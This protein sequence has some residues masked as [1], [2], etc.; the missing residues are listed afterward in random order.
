MQRCSGYA[1]MQRTHNTGVGR[2]Q[3]PALC[4]PRRRNHEVWSHREE[5][6]GHCSLSKNSSVS[7]CLPLTSRENHIKRGM[8]QTKKCKA[9]CEIK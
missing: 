8:K 7:K 6:P 3:L 2:G 5:E 4:N 1:V 9:V